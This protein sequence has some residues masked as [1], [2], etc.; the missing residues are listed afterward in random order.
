MLS[1]RIDEGAMPF[2]IRDPE[3][4]TLVRKLARE[5]GVGLTDAVKLAVARELERGT[6]EVAQRLER[7]R[8]I[9]DVIARSPR[10]GRKA[11]KAFFDEL[12]GD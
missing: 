2:H 7:M 1:S 6:D 12:S 11:D 4:D 5:R 3:T 10:T 9:T 8:A